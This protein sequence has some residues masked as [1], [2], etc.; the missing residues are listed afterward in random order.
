MWRLTPSRKTDELR[1]LKKVHMS[2]NGD[3]G[4]V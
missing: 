2:A 1:L 4:I 3:Y